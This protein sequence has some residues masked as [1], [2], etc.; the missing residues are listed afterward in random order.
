MYELGMRDAELNDLNELY[1]QHYYYYRQGYDKRRTQLRRAA[2]LSVFSNRPMISL[3]L[4]LVS[5]SIIAAL[6]Y[7]LLTN[8]IS[9]NAS[10]NTVGGTPVVP[11]TTT[12]TMVLTPTIAVISPTDI[13][14]PFLH[15]GAQAQVINVGISPLLGRTR[16]GINNPIQT[17]FPDGA[18]VTI[19][20]GPVEADG[21]VWWLIT[22]EESGEGWSAERGPDGVV[23]LQPI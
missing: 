21:Y 22:S 3:V 18:V 13:P 23:W 8:S 5:C 1:Y 20:E 10:K 16:P 19:L 2:T 6:G 14:V 9:I 4:V 11:P 12:P 15:P 17:S 7:I